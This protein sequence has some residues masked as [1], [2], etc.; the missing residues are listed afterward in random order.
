MEEVIGEIRTN[1]E[2]KRI[3]GEVKGS[4]K[5]PTLIC[6]GGI[7]G[8]ELAGVRALEEVLAELGSMRYTIRGTMVGVRGNLPAQEVGKRFLTQDLNRLWTSPSIENI[9][10]KNKNVRTAEEAQLI[11]LYTLVHQVLREAGPPFYFIDLHTTSSKTIPFITIND[12]MI[13][14]KFSQNFPVPIVL[15]IEEYI[16]GP[17]LSYMNELGYVSLGFESGQHDE[18]IAISNARSFLW[19]TVLLT[20]LVKQEEV[21]D[22]MNYY[23]QLKRSVGDMNEFY[24]VTY[25]EVL[26]RDDRF[27]MKSGFENFQHIKKGTLLGELNGQE[28]P[29]EH[30]CILFM[31]LYQEQGE[32]AFFLLRRTPKWA[33][34]VSSF[35]RKIRLDALLTLLP[36][37]SWSNGS[38]KALLVDLN[39]ARFFTKPFFHLL[40]YRNRVKDETHFLM[41]NRERSAQSEIYKNEKWY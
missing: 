38:K 13:N 40:G 28:I 4:M 14:R 17:L 26:T 24:E 9:L 23:N 33:L 6:F 37:I 2:A 3:I 29:A 31:P 19:L 1:L 22:F 30:D 7:H 8:N 39:I 21:P 11:E 5:G 20:G 35:F 25:R 27:V 15:G 16:S 36:G 41:N 10:G 18:E 32:D 34:K 12:A